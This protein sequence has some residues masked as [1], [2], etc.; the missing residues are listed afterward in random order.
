MPG[1]PPLHQPVERGE[2]AALAAGGRLGQQ[3]RLLLGEDAAGGAQAD[4]G[5]GDGGG[6]YGGGGAQASAPRDEEVPG[7]ET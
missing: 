6:R 3:G 2:A 5:L 4:G 7:R 1:S